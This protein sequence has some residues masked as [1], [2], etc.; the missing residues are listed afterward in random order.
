MAQAQVAQTLETL[1][2]STRTLLMQAEQ[3]R[4]LAQGITVALVGKPNVGKSSIL[5]ALAGEEAAIVTDVPGTTRDLLKVDINVGGMPLQVV[6]TAG[7]R[8]TA[9]AVERI[10]V[11]RARDQILRADHVV[12]VVTAAEVVAN[13]AHLLAAKDLEELLRTFAPEATPELATVPADSI[14]LLINK[15]D[16]VDPPHQAEH[17]WP[18]S[19][20]SA[21]TGAGLQAFTKKLVERGS[22]GVEGTVF[23]ARLRHVQSLELV[24]DL[25]EQAEQ[26][27][28]EGVGAE[29]IAEDCRL[30]HQ[31]L[32]Q[33]V[34]TV[35]ADDLLGEIFSSFC[36]G[37]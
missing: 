14:H 2:A 24:K 19:Y 11:Q 36:I 30:A 1:I 16:L 17:T 4:R 31:A 6:D 10:G 26:G 7:L 29:L 8:D 32:G 15:I 35:S 37:K 33:I 21:K 12:L 34:G 28:S 27:L 22:G 25:L 3:G 13:D 18:V 9:D 20:V 5:N 23:S